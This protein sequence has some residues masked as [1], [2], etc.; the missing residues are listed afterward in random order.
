MT[1]QIDTLVGRISA[2][3][4]DISAIKTQYSDIKNRLL[5]AAS[6]LGHRRRFFIR[7]AV[8]SGRRPKI[9]TVVN[10]YKC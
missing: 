10:V 2:A 9:S 4:A 5:G 1:S 8:L 7:L 3:E 6:L